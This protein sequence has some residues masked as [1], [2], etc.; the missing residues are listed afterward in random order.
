MCFVLVIFRWKEVK[1]ALYTF[2]N[3]RNFRVG[4]LRDFRR[5]FA[6]VAPVFLERGIANVET[7]VIMKTFYYRG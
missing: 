6:H 1:S 7:K 2:P 4:V 3:L 5:V